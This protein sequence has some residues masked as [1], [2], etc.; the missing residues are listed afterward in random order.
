MLCRRKPVNPAGILRRFG[1]DRREHRGAAQLHRNL[2]RICLLCQC[3]PFRKLCREC[4]AVFVCAFLRVTFARPSNKRYRF[5]FLTAFCHC[6]NLCRKQ[7]RDI[8]KKCRHLLAGARQGSNPRL[9]VYEFPFIDP[10]PCSDDS[11]LCIILHCFFRNLQ[12]CLCALRHCP[13]RCRFRLCGF[14]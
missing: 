3:I 12:F 4:I 9:R 2:Q 11:L 8:F 13:S 10:F 6:Q 5:L 1:I 7:F 14:W